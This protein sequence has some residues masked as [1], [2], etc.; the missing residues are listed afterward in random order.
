MGILG[1]ILGLAGGSFLGGAGSA[2]GANIG[3]GLG[4]KGKGA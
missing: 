1:P 4:N 3:A 2:A